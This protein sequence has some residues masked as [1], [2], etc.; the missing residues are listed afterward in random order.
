[1]LILDE[2]EVDVNG[3]LE[4]DEVMDVDDET[5]EES[6]EGQAIDDDG[7]PSW[8]PEEAKQAYEQAGDD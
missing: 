7:D 6:Q 2:N 4:C 3:G 5:T 8:T 1:V